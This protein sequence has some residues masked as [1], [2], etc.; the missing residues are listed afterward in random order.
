MT[1]KNTVETVF[2]IANPI[3][4]EMGLQLWDIRFEKE[5]PNWFLRIFIDKESNININDCETFSRKLDPIL[6][7]ID[8]IEQSYY[9]E[10]SSPGVERE[11]VKDWHIK[12]YIGHNVN[13]KFIRPIDNKKEITGRLVGFENNIITIFLDKDNLE[14][15]F[16]KKEVATIKLKFNF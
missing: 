12:K 11:L 1:K 9:L 6:D 4:K 16:N 5:G 7:E 14:S 8:P 13:I 10:V 15:S 3:A 2:D